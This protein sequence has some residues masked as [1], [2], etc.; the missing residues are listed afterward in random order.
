LAAESTLKT[1]P[2]QK[3]KGHDRV[4]TPISPLVRKSMIEIKTVKHLQEQRQLV[5][6]FKLSFRKDIST[7]AWEWK[8]LTGPYAALSAEVI[9]AVDGEKIVGARPYLIT[10]LWQGNQKILAAQHCDTMV[11][12]A[13]RNHGL[14]NRLGERGLAY[15]KENN[16]ALS[17]GFPGPM[18]RVGF[19]K[20]GYRIVIPTEIMFRPVSYERILGKRLNKRRLGKRL[21]YLFDRAPNRIPRQVRPRHDD[22]STQVFEHYDAELK[23]IDA[24]H[25]P[26]R[27][28]YVRN[29][30]NLRWRFDNH[31]E[32]TYRY[33]T[34]KR[35]SIL[36]GYAV[37]S[38]QKQEHDLMY[39]MIVDFLLKSAE[40][41][42]AAALIERAI[43]ELSKAECDLL[44]V[45]AFCEPL[46][47]QILKRH[48]GFKATLRFPYN[49]M[50]DSGYFEAMA[51][52]STML[53][54]I[55]IYRPDSWRI[56]YIYPDYA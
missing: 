52:N 3:R 31:P 14:F 4:K 23:A 51:L 5:D 27:I 6:L 16:Y 34:V 30:N 8:Y 17:F 45:W 44:A 37:I 7:R 32:H 13:Y 10:E 21:G 38:V 33:I 20:Q 24:W 22:I 11:H 41:D 18:A 43:V 19:L 55:D 36:C 47:S 25:K 2:V 35:N 46:V 49:K 56:T 50:I 42:C 15:L 54:G 9:V 1:Y 48:Y 40:P 28:E 26:D 39:G 29:E 12:P 53:E